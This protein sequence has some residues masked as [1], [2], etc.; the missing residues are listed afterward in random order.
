MESKNFTNHRSRK[1]NVNYQGLV[2]GK[3][4]AMS[5]KGYK[6]LISK[7]NFGISVVYHGDC[8]L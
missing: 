1:Q 8:K 3:I 6:T 7:S 4:G 2:V 5:F